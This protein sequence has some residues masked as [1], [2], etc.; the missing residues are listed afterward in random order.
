MAR[1]AKQDSNS[2][3]I[4]GVIY[5]RYSEGPN[6][7]EASIEGQV[8]ECKEYAK[9]NG[10]RIINVYS[11]SKHTGTNDNRAEFQK[12]L[13][14]SRRGGFSVVV[15]WKIDRFGRNR[16]EMAQNKALLKLQGVKVVSAKEY[17]PDSPEGIILESVLEGMA[18]YYSANLS[19]NIKRGMKENALHCKSNGSGKSLGYIV[20]KDGYFEIEPNEATIVK[21]IYQKYDEGMKIADIWREIVASGAKTKRGKDFTQY[22]ISRVLCNRAY[23]GEYRYGDIVTPGGMPRIIDDDLF[24]RVQE[25]RALRKKAPASRRSNSDVDFLLTGKVF[26]GHCKGTMRG[27]SGTSKTGRKFYYYACHDKIFKHNKCTKKNVKKEWLETEVT[28]ITRDDILNK[29]T[30]EFIADRVVEIQRQEQEDKSMLHYYEQQLRDTQ[31]AI[32]NIMKA[33]EAGIITSSTKSRLFELEEQKSII[34]GEIEREKIITPVIE[35]EQV[36]FSLERFF[37]GDINN[38]EYQRNI[39]DM[40]VNKVILYDDKIIITYNIS[41]QNEISVD[42]VEQAA[43]AALDECSSKLSLAPPAGACPCTQFRFTLCKAVF[44]CRSSILSKTQPLFL[45]GG[46]FPSSFFCKHTKS[47]L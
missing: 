42:V 22:G 4:D 35:K 12:M 29:E 34:E 30:I 39:I 10:I 44:Y 23:I 20:D 27:M 28:R 32:N 26:C 41:S 3:I 1:A 40:F 11:D 13:R 7:T 45:R 2:E 18:E 5:A 16:A 47:P 14:D 38:K 33:I 37:G 8:R 31:S 9:R 36:I 21:T 43:F 17:I 6:Q 46:H 19:Q 24:N 25:R 15:V